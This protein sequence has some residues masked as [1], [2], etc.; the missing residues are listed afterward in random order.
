MNQWIEIENDKF[1]FKK[2]CKSNVITYNILFFY[3]TFY[4][5]K[6]GN[7]IIAFHYVPFQ[8]YNL[9]I[10][11][12]IAHINLLLHIIIISQSLGTSSLIIQELISSL[13]VPQTE[14][15]RT[16]FISTFLSRTLQRKRRHFWFS[17]SLFQYKWFLK[18]LTLFLQTSRC[19]CNLRDK[20]ARH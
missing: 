7:R 10:I 2:I 19:S 1:I 15:R 4:M 11:V 5:N 9:F 8:L 18:H 12:F 3:A 20:Q 16:P 14:N 13:C 6:W 17:A